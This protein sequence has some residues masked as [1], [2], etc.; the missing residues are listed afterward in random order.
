MSDDILVCY[1]CGSERVT[2]SAYVFVNTR[3][4]QEIL[5]DKEDYFCMDCNSDTDVVNKFEY[6]Y[7]NNENMNRIE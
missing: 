1:K 5:Y 3:E 6:E 2:V 7:N 4:V